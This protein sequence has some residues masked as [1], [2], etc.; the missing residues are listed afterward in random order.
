MNSR[1]FK[2]ASVLTDLVENYGVIGVKTSFEDEGA[3]FEEVL[4]LKEICNQAKTKLN[5][6]VGGP[7]AIRDIIDST[8]IGTKGL[9]GPMI[10][11]SFGLQK[12][13]KACKSNLPESSYKV[14]NLYVNTETITALQNIESLVNIPEFEELHGV[15]IGRVDLVGSMGKDRSYVNSKEILD[16]ARKTFT[17]V[18]D[19]GVKACIGGAVSVD[20]EEFLKT[21]HSEGLLDKFE[22]RYIIFDPTIALKNLS[23]S[24][25]KA[26]I[27]EYE[28]MMAKHESHL[29]LANRELKRIQMIQD[30]INSSTKNV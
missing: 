15:T 30:R 10:E 14:T 28:W 2:C 12:F 20:S 19:K 25:M 3:T 18:K 23:K 4:R 26:Q 11:S 17:L 1:E 21:L 6:K 24:L 29:N 16:L 9:V 8:Q 27:F 7:E 5:L 13:I 22:T